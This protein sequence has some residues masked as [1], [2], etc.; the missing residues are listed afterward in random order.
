M[1]LLQFRRLIIFLFVVC[2][3]SFGYETAPGTKT[4]DVQIALGIEKPKLKYS[5]LE[6]SFYGYCA[7]LDVYKLPHEMLDSFLSKEKKYNM[8][9]T[10]YAMI[11][12]QKGRLDSITESKLNPFRTAGFFV[13]ERDKRIYYDYLDDMDRLYYEEKSYYTIIYDSVSDYYQVL[14]ID[15]VESKLFIHSYFPN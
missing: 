7:E 11:N 6:K 4:D 3:L 5:D 15:T 14:L 2:V 12:W 10:D 1:N 9:E 13:G 8:L